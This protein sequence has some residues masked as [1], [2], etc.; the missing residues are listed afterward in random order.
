M[1]SNSGER[2]RR[3]APTEKWIKQRLESLQDHLGS[4]A[5]TDISQWLWQ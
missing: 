4:N 3:E 5:D 2:L 1:L